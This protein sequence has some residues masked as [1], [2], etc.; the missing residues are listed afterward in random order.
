MYR[1][2]SPLTPDL[3]KN[4]L[5]LLQN[6]FN[7]Y[8]TYQKCVWGYMEENS[9]P[10]VGVPP[11]CIRAGSAKTQRLVG[12][13]ALNTKAGKQNFGARISSITPFLHFWQVWVKFHWFWRHGWDFQADSLNSGSWR[14]EFLYIYHIIDPENGL[15]FMCQ[16]CRIRKYLQL[17]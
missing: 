15:D 8:Q 6:Q 9:A 1:N 11:A 13:T 2:W 5:L 7:F 16:I 12:A 14:R 3:E 10:K 17:K 4:S